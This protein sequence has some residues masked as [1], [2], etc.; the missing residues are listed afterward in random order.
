[1][2]Q[3]LKT[4]AKQKISNKLVFLFIIS[5]LP[6]GLTAILA[7]I[8]PLAFIVGILITFGV[9]DIFYKV[10][11]NQSSD[12]KDV[13]I[14]FKANDIQRYLV[15]GLRAVVEIFLYSLLLLIPG[16]IKAYEYSQ[17]FYLA[18]Q[19]P[20]LSPKEVLLES[21]RIMSGNKMNLF[22]LQL[23]FIGWILL[24]II[25]FGIAN[26]YVMPLYQMTMTEFYLKVKN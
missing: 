14:A 10:A 5:V 1:M 20:E 18:N 17:V 6:A 2:N 3:E 16:I 4:Q 26:I 15:I 21:S 22:L 23:S 7:P 11:T 8:F 9:H 25:T 19:R 24:V 12:Y 13:A